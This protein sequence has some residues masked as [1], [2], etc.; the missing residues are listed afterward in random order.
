[1]MI[2]SSWD[3]TSPW[4]ASCSPCSFVIL[5]KGELELSTAPHQ[6]TPVFLG[7]RVHIFLKWTQSACMG[8][9]NNDLWTSASLIVLWHRIFISILKSQNQ[10]HVEWNWFPLNIHEC[11]LKNQICSTDLTVQAFGAGGALSVSNTDIPT[12]AQKNCFTF[13]VEI[14]KKKSW[15]AAALLTLGHFNSQTDQFLTIRW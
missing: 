10:S 1:M 11:F 14:K 4:R 6:Q 15:S 9:K 7:I 8:N 5:S 12:Q 3:P 2:A 13:F